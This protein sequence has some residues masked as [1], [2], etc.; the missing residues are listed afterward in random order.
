MPHEYV[1]PHEAH[2]GFDPTE[3]HQQGERA[4]EIDP[5]WATFNAAA[6]EGAAA[7]GSVSG[8]IVRAIGE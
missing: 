1:S 6:S 3:P 5:S 4:G 7:F 2:R 8:G